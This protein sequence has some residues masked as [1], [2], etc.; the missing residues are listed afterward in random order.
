MNNIN[1]D[2]LYLEHTNCNVYYCNI[3]VGI[4]DRLSTCVFDMPA[5]MCNYSIDV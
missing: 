4:S 1:F 2:A 5:H 3:E